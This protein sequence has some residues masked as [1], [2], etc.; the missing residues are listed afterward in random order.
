MMGLKMPLFNYI[1]SKGV[2]DCARNDEIKYND[3]KDWDFKLHI[4]LD[5]LLLNKNGATP[6]KGIL[7]GLLAEAVSQQHIPMYKVLKGTLSD[8]FED[9]RKSPIV[10]R[11][12]NL[13]Y[14]LY[15][16]DHF[17]R[18]NLIKVALLVGKIEKELAK[19]SPS[20]IKSSSDVELS[21]HV[22]F[23]CAVLNNNYHIAATAGKDVE[24]Q[25][26]KKGEDSKHYQFLR[27]LLIEIPELIK[28]F[29]KKHKI[30]ITATETEQI[31]THMLNSML[32]LPESCFEN[33]HGWLLASLNFKTIEKPRLFCRPAQCKVLEFKPL[34]VANFENSSS[35]NSQENEEIQAIFHA[36]ETQSADEIEVRFH[37]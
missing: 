22:T 13:P 3:Q 20:R 23:R 28:G 16:H 1:D 14:T 15:L 29:C 24:A 37:L 35:A 7:N 32:D 26:K 19:I 11:A 34:P 30:K 21:P 2:F 5:V 12:C 25:L 6:L 10:V 17:D 4:R 18:K 27:F 33:I 36:D 31:K 9:I 8:F